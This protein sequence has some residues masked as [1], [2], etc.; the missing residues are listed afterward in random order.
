MFLSRVILLLTLT[1]SFISLSKL[2]DVKLVN[3]FTY[4]FSP[5][6]TRDSNLRQLSSLEII[7]TGSNKAVKP[8]KYEGNFDYIYYFEVNFVKL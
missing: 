3:D 2:K 5:T 8:S 1:I 6:P 4:L 7:D